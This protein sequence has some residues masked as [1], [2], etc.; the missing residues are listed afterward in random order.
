[1][2]HSRC[3][4]KKCISCNVVI[5]QSKF[6]RID[7]DGSIIKSLEYGKNFNFIHVTC[8]PSDK[9]W[10]ILNRKTFHQFTRE[11]KKHMLFQYWVLRNKIYVKDIIWMIISYTVDPYGP[12]AQIQNGYKMTNLCKCGNLLSYPTPLTHYKSECSRAIC[13]HDHQFIWG[14]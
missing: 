3:V 12:A 9:Y 5:G 1:M 2:I 6:K 11:Y 4:P 13:I 10:P 7:E 8:L 14:C